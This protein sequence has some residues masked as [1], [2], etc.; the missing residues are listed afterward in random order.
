MNIYIIQGNNVSIT[1]NN[2][3]RGIG[4]GYPPLIDVRYKN[5]TS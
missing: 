3:R 2:G 4:M 5:A 1:I